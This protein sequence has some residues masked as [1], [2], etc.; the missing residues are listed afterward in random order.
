MKVLYLIL[1]HLGG[2]VLLP[3]ELFGQ[4]STRAGRDNAQ[5]PGVTA[6]VTVDY[7]VGKFSK[8]EVRFAVAFRDFSIDASRG[9]TYEGKTYRQEVPGLMELLEKASGEFPTVRFDVYYGPHKQGTVE[10]QISARDGNLGAFTGDG[11]LFATTEDKV[12]NLSPWRLEAVFLESFLYRPDPTLW[13]SAEYRIKDYLKAKDQ[14]KKYED[15]IREADASFNG[16]A[17]EQELTK[18]RGLYYQAKQLKSSEPYPQDQMARIDERIKAL[19][20]KE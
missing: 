15:K 20:Q 2:V 12:N 17:T 18:A 5:A 4:Q 13:T 16:A 11:I 8:T 3:S 14:Q 9:Y 10:Y 19:R 7:K 6:I 1:I